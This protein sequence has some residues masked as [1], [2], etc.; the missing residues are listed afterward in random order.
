M[1]EN[2]KIKV[3]FLGGLHSVHDE[4][5]SFGPPGIEF[6][7][8]DPQIKD[9]L[10][11]LSHRA[12][13]NIVP[14]IME[15]VIHSYN[16]V[17]LNRRNWVLEIEHISSPRR[18][19]GSGV[20]NLLVNTFREKIMDNKNKMR[21][22]GILDLVKPY[23]VINSLRSSYCKKIIAWSN[24]AITDRSSPLYSPFE[25]KIIETKEI[26]DKFCVV[27]PAM[28]PRKS[29]IHARNGKDLKLLFVGNGFFRKGGDIVIRA[30]QELKGKYHLSL[31]IVSNFEGEIH[32]N[33]TKS[34][35]LSIKDVLIKDE[36]V[37][38]LTNV[39]RE[40]MLNKVYLDHDIF[41]MP[42][43]A[44]LFAFSIIEAMHSKLPIISTK[45]GAIPEMVEDGVNGFLLESPVNNYGPAWDDEQRETIKNALMEKITLFAENSR[46]IKEMGEVSS[47]IAR[48]KFS[49]QLRNE[50]LKEVYLE[51][52]E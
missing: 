2:N 33:Q 12:G 6:K 48:E 17:V 31:T 19:V 9:L 14:S 22:P 23:V 34:L 52:Y 36:K 43:N 16:R 15:D 42:T 4:M 28:K 44:D 13:I 18:W 10:F 3:A 20:T 35:G 26:A 46:L 39:D 32:Y 5:I 50:K 7:V 11:W 40:T 41:V 21:I 30:F 27:Y 8:Y 1:A 49:Y 29:K 24:W 51:A 47:E 45:I 25:K 37:I 38:W